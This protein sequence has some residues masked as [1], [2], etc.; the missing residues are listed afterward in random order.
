MI[1]HDWETWGGLDLTRSAA[2]GLLLGFRCALIYIKGDWAEYAGTYG[3]PAWADR[4][5][6]CYKCNSSVEDLYCLQG[7][8][9]ICCGK[10]K[11][12]SAED[13]WKACERCE[14]LV[15]LSRET[16]AL[17]SSVL[18]YDKRKDGSKGLALKF[19]P[20]LDSM[21]LQVGWRLE[22]SDWLPAMLGNSKTFRY[23]HLP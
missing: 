9:P 21:G 20:D 23:S 16:H 12:N 5:R 17:L 8:S 2:A 15:V 14:H 13:Y 10:F 6:P 3:F 18:A 7:L 22:P 11:E 1:R 4:F 19:H